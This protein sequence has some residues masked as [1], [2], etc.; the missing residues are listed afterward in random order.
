MGTPETR[1]ARPRPGRWVA[2]LGLVAALAGTQGSFFTY[3][4]L[5]ELA[6]AGPVSERF[7]GTPYVPRWV[8]YA[9]VAILAVSLVAALFGATLTSLAGSLLAAGGIAVLPLPMMEVVGNLGYDS[10]SELG[11]GYF[12]M[13]AGCALAA[14]ASAIDVRR[15]V[16]RDSAREAPSPEAWTG[17]A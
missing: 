4:L 6:P 16:N 1:V 12:A 14:L 2:V 13:V 3:R 5:D 9:M 11:L 10:S 15:R 17:E 7:L 8:L